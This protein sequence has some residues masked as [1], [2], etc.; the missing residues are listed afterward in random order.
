MIIAVDFDGVLCE[1]R[2]PQIGAPN[3]AMLIWL[4]T[5]KLEGH[6]IILWTCRAGKNLEDAVKWCDEHGLRFDAVNE[7]LKENIEMYGTDTRKV[8]ANIYIDDQNAPAWFLDKFH[9]PYQHGQSYLRDIIG[10][11]HGS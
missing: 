8:Y 2:F 7:N 6:K 9:I 3:K 11:R 4:F 5:K 10:G 1:K